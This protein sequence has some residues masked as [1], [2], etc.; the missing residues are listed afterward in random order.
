V[1]IITL[2]NLIAVIVTL[3]LRNRPG[4][5]PLKSSTT[6]S[7][8]L[9]FTKKLHQDIIDNPEDVMKVRTVHKIVAIRLQKLGGF[10]DGV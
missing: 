8:I 9:G 6:G 4:L 10:P 5:Y 1:Y 2:P 3:E 7:T